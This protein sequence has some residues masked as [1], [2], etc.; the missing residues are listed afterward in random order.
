MA[1]AYIFCKTF[2]PCHAELFDT[3]HSSPILILFTGS[4]PVVSHFFPIRVEN[5]V[6]PDQMAS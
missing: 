5:S 4:I 3:L 6:D 2:N 1:L